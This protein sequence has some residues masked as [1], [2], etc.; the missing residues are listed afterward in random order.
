MTDGNGAHY[1]SPASK[2][3]RAGVLVS[4]LL[5]AGAA[6]AWDADLDPTYHS[7]GRAWAGFVGPAG[8]DSAVAVAV[9]TDGKVVMAGSRFNGSDLDFG[10][11]RLGLD[12]YPDNTFGQSGTAY[13]DF[14]SATDTAR[15]MV[16]QP[17]GKIVVVG[18][19]RVGGVNRM[20][21]ARFHPD[22]SL[23]DS[24]TVPFS[25]STYGFGVALQPD[26]KIVICGRTYYASSLYDF[27]VARLNSN[28]TMDT[29]F[30]SDGMADWDFGD[31]DNDS[32]NDIE[33]RSDGRIVVAGSAMWN[34]QNVFGLMVFSATGG[35]LNLGVASFSEDAYGFGL[36]LQKDGKAVVSGRCEVNG[37]DFAVARF[38]TNGTLDTTFSTDGMDTVIVSGNEE[39]AMDVVVQH[40]GKIL[41][42]G[43]MNYNGTWQLALMRWK[44]DGAL[45]FTFNDGYIYTYIHFFYGY[46]ARGYAIAQQ[47]DGKIL[48]AGYTD[49]E[50]GRLMAVARIM[51]D[52]DLIFAED[53]ESGTT[54]WWSSSLN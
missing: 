35:P 10:V 30:S 39:S 37:G 28:L 33:V 54:D 50:S 34:G 38:N 42:V 27:A 4:L 19:A 9:Q 22:G 29:T 15:D 18:N 13:F 48:A 7:G 3:G 21:V 11:I 14:D 1:L 23:D 47:P 31:N 40:N 16:I 8:Q 24:T 49:Y 6:G 17:D 44:A 20:G 41:T 45:D 36:D 51:G 12:G 25:G 2:P 43:Y 5:F 53:L 46:D 32:A 26:G 52:E